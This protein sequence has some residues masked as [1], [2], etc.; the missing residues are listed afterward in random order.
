MVY[1]PGIVL[2]RDDDGEWRSP[3]EVDVLTSAAV[4]AGE[5]R[6]KLER[7]ER[8][9]KAVEYLDKK[10][11][12]G[13]K[14]YERVI[15]ERKKRWGIKKPKEEKAKLTKEQANLVKE[16][17]KGKAK[18]SGIVLI[19]DGDGE[20]HSPVEGDALTTAAVNAGEI[21]RELGREEREQMEYQKKKGEERGKEIERVVAERQRLREEAKNEKE[22]EERAKLKN[23]VKEM[24][25]RKET[26]IGKAKESGSEKEGPFVE[27]G[28]AVAEV[29]IQDGKGEEVEIEKPEENQE[30]T[31]NSPD[32]G[33][34]SLGCGSDLKG[35]EEDTESKGTLIQ[36][37]QSQ[38]EAPPEVNQPTSYSTIVHPLSS[39]T[40]PSQAPVPK[41]TYDL[42]LEHAEVQI[43]QI[44]YDRISRILHLFQLH[45]TPHL[46]LG[47]F[48][49][50]V[51][52]NSV[53]RIARIFADLLI[54]PGGR[55]EGVFQ[56]V[57]FPILGKETSGEVYDVFY[58]RAQRERRGKTLVLKDSFGSL[59]G[60]DGDVKEG[61]KEKTMRIARWKASRSELGRIQRNP[62]MYDI[63]R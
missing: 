8:S 30:N 18:D 35:A 47:S 26:D 4:N 32:G 59:S 16:T 39:S 41:L 50:G 31:I 53:D 29:E 20:W 55:F 44:M 54:K 17:D 13:R 21:R 24:G 7:E 34:L 14:E 3:V 49:T 23:L 62:F 37:D 33:L 28:K 38:P 60:N 1:S 25:K 11:E 51:S 6:R 12:E 9:R 43:E 52:E 57:V 2:I 63:L 22:R 42:A 58:K 46:I 48:G 10:R 27:Q 36:D 61:D 5:I 45:Q 40:R 15:S 19:R 56:T